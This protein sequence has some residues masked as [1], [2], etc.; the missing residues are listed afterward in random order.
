MSD[1]EFYKM[2]AQNSTNEARL[3]QEEDMISKVSMILVIISSL[4]VLQLTRK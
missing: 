1:E 2:M 4:P 3:A